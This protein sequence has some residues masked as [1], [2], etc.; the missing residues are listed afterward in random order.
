MS[1]PLSAEAERAQVPPL[2][3][4]VRGAREQG[5]GQDAEGED[6][7]LDAETWRYRCMVTIRG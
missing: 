4:A 6:V 5:R 7:V 3:G 1:E 2:D